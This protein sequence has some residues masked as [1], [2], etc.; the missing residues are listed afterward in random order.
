MLLNMTLT[1]MSIPL[2]L[3]PHHACCQPPELTSIPGAAGIK[4]ALSLSAFQLT[5]APGLPT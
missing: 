1:F 4:L 2:R 5:A 3:Y